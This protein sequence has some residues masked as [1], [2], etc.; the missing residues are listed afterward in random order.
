MHF[1]A[2][3]IRRRR[4]F[5]LG[6]GMYLVLF[7]IMI[8]VQLVDY[9]KNYLLYVSAKEELVNMYQKGM[10]ANKMSNQA[11][12]VEYLHSLSLEGLRQAFYTS[13]TFAFIGINALLIV[14]G[15]SKI[16]KKMRKK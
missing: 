6:I 10:T 14:W 11:D 15:A 8:F 3:Y 4:P 5:I 1:I 13:A 2:E 9:F 7:L 12:I 16:D